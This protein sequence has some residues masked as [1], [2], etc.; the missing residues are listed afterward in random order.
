MLT[1]LAVAFASVQPASAPEGLPFLNG[2]FQDHMVLQ[3][4]L[5]NTFWGWTVPGEKVSVTLAG[6]TASASAGSD[7]KWVVKVKPPKVGGPYTLSVDGS[8]HVVLKDLLVGDVWLCTGQSNMEFGTPMAVNGQAEVAAANH[9]DIR[10]TMVQHDTQLDPRPS[11]PVVWSVCTPDSITKGGWAGFSAVGYFFGRELNKRLHVPIGLV[12]DCWGGTPAESWMSSEA[13]TREG[14]FASSLARINEAR[15]SHSALYG[16]Q[17]E[18]WLEKVD[19]GTQ[20]GWQSPDFDDSTWKPVAAMPATFQDLGMDYFPG[21]VWFRGRVDLPDP[22][23]A[24]SA[25]ISL[26]AIEDL[27]ETW[28]DGQPVGE[29]YTF[30]QPR[31]YTVPAGVLKPGRNDIA[32]RVLATGAGGGFTWGP[33]AFHLSFSSGSNVDLSKGTWKFATGANIWSQP[34]PIPQPLEGSPYVPSILY[35]GMIQP[36]AGL[37]I[38]GAIWYQGESNAGRAYQYRTVLPDMIADWRN[39]W[40]EGDFPFLIVQLANFQARAANPGDSDWAELR[41]AQEMTAAGVRNA[42]IATAIDVGD[43]RDIH[44]KDKQTVGLRLALDALHVAYGQR[45]AYSGPIYRSFKRDGD[46]IRIA[47]DHVD[48]GLNAKGVNLGGFAI[49]GSDHKFHWAD[50]RIDG[51]TVV[52]RSGDVPDPVAVRYGW[53]NNPEITLYNGAGLPALP[54]RTDDWPGVTYGRK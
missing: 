3:R 29:T 1:T 34:P 2:I 43:D 20:H 45:L 31:D 23:P 46:A 24:G 39:A 48:G 27:D 30:N 5:P 41:E 28:V 19:P 40:G 10:L 44:P 11:T 4:D 26:G 8:K 42:G 52:V 53:A 35:N 49:A 33:E 21:V 13:L 9:P 6:R 15:N 32:I 25:S 37:A 18:E 22:I 7:G 38:K 17:I 54:F 47:F 50:A 16:H 51:D 36:V 14:D 12:Q